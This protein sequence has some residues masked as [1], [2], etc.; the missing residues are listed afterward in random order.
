MRLEYTENKHLVLDTRKEIGNAALSMAIA[1]FGSNGYIVS[2]PLN[3]TQDYDLIV[4]KNGC[5]QRVQVKGTNTTRTRSAYTVGLRSISGTS[6]Q[7]YKTVKETNIDLLFCLCGDGTMYVI[8][9]ED[10]KNSSALNLSKDK[11]KYSN[12]STVDYS[13][14]IVTM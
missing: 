14:Y 3:D 13:K 11:N 10:I 12:K 5:V 6:R 8:P 1:Y 9:I 2:I 7:A 4:D